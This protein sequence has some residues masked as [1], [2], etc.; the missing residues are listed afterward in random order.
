MGMERHVPV[1]DA[2]RVLWPPVAERLS[3]AGRPVQMRMIDGQLA[4]PDETPPTGWRELRVAGAAGVMVTVR[5]GDDG[6]T[7]VT[8][9][10]ADDDTAA[11]RDAIADSLQAAGDG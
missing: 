7:L 4:L 1:A 2:D 3:R 9:G 6:F 8:W 10:N 11:L 5:R